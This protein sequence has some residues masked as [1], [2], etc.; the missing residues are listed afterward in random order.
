MK[1]RT[2]DVKIPRSDALPLSHRDLVVGKFTTEIGTLI[3]KFWF[4]S[5]SH[6]RG[7]IKNIF[8]HLF[9]ELKIY[10]ISYSIHKKKSESNYYL[11]CKHRALVPGFGGGVGLSDVTLHPSIE[12]L[13]SVDPL[14]V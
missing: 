10:H 6:A 3:L 2:T 13:V 7:K 14:A 11:Q 12:A 9:N 1:N 8:L 4:F 5:L